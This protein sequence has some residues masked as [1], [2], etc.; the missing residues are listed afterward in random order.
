MVF[1]F[2][3]PLIPSLVDIVALVYSVID[4]CA[5]ALVTTWIVHHLPYGL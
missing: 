4:F 3:N 1:F 5:F 2:F